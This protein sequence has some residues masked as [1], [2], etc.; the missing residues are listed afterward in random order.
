LTTER[1]RAINRDT[2]LL[3]ASVVGVATGGVLWFADAR[4]AADIAWTITTVLGLVPLLFETVRSVRRGK[5]GV[6]LIALL[7]LAGALALGEYLAGAVI[8][9]KLTSGRAHE[10]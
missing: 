8:E 9:D 4:D 10:D 2:V 3:A 5:A 7:A 1:P 6:D